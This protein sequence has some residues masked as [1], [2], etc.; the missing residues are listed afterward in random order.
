MFRDLDA[1]I[2]AKE[3]GRRSGPFRSPSPIFLFTIFLSK[4]FCRI[5][6]NPDEQ[7]GYPKTGPSQST[8]S[9]TPSGRSSGLPCRTSRCKASRNQMQRFAVI[10]GRLRWFAPCCAFREFFRRTATTATFSRHLSISAVPIILA[11]ANR[12]SKIA[13]P[14]SLPLLTQR[15]QYGTATKTSASRASRRLQIRKPCVFNAYN[16]FCATT[17]PLP[18]SRSALAPPLLLASVP[19]SAG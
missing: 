1:S 14:H 10:C 19:R 12:K 16:H 5:R 9:T 18:P 13:N 4:S 2:E 17:L 11:I 8:T 3:I 6:T 7:G 15:E